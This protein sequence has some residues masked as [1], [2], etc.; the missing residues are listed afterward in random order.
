VGKGGEVWGG[1]DEDHHNVLPR[2]FLHTVMGPGQCVVA[3]MSNGINITP[4]LDWFHYGI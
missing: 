3:T 4:L 1:S 2:T